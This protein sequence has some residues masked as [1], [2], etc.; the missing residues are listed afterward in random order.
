MFFIICRL[1]K[2]C[3]S[4]FV[5]RKG[6]QLHQW[7]TTHH[8]WSSKGKCFPC[9]RPI[10]SS[11]FQACDL[12]KHRKE[13][14]ERKLTCKNATSMCKKAAV[15][16]IFMRMPSLDVKMPV[17]IRNLYENKCSVPGKN[18][19]GKPRLPKATGCKYNYRDHNNINYQ[20]TFCSWIELSH[21]RGKLW[22]Q[23]VKCSRDFVRDLLSPKPKCDQRDL[24][25][26]HWVWWQ[27]LGHWCHPMPFQQ[28]HWRHKRLPTWAE[29]G[30]QFINTILWSIQILRSQLPCLVS[31]RVLPPSNLPW[32]K[33]SQ[34][35]VDTIFFRS[36]VFVQN[37]QPRGWHNI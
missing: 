32:C 31:T 36:T 4:F 22:R 12:S 9:P 37:V 13:A 21:I 17:I 11:S 1:Q 23:G 3:S 8:H 6:M 24:W 25:S 7:H 2:L 14:L 34:L 19:F 29:P 10:K 28:L 33:A 30:V 16:A 35:Q 18:C 5:N 20:K 27:V 26:R 15:T